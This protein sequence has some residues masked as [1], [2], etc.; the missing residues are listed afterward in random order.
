VKGW[1]RDV[2][3]SVTPARDRVIFAPMGPE[4]SDVGAFKLTAVGKH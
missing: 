2:G 4:D 3:F 1:L